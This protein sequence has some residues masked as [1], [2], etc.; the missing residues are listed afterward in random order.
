MFKD[1][2]NTL[3]KKGVLSKKAHDLQQL[4][5]FIKGH[6][7]YG[8]VQ[9][10]LHSVPTRVAQRFGCLKFT[11]EI[12]TARQFRHA[13]ALPLEHPGALP[14]VNTAAV[15]LAGISKKLVRVGTGATWIL[16]TAIGLYEIGEAP[17]EEKFEKS[18]EVT[19]EVVVG[20]ML[21]FGAESIVAPALVAF[22]GISS[23]GLAF[24]IVALCVGGAAYA[25]GEIG[26]GVMSRLVKT[27]K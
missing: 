27:L 11:A 19:G 16:P 26:K 20:A 6:P 7:N 2:V 5:A 18:M 13:I 21:G 24:V 14:Y 17:P 1:A 9:N 3:G 23:G 8:K 25:G 10:I 15:E 4:D 12:Q 22:L